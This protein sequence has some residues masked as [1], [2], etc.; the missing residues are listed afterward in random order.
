MACSSLALRVG[1]SIITDK[2][3]KSSTMCESDSPSCAAAERPG[4]AADQSGQHG[5]DGYGISACRFSIPL[6]RVRQEIG[7]IKEKRSGTGN[8]FENF[9]KKGD[10]RARG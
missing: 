8:Y 9:E 7:S 4:V 5:Q 10:R 2:P 1:I 3:G 6:S